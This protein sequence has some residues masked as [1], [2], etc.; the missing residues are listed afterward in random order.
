MGE[1]FDVVHA[2][3]PRNALTFTALFL[4]K[5]QAVPTVLTPHC[6]YPSHR[7]LEGAAKWL[8]DSVVMPRTFNLADRVINLTE[9]DCRDSLARGL[10]P[11]KC[12]IIPNSVRVTELAGVGPVDFRRKWALPWDFILHI[13]RFDWVKNIEFLVRAQVHLKP[14]GLV[15]IGQDD[16]RLRAV[17]HLVRR[18]RL[19]EYVRIIPRASFK[20]VC[21]AYQQAR[22]VV[23]ASRYE[24]LPTVVLEA[25]Y[26]G[27]PVVASRVGGIPYVL[28]DESIGMCYTLNDQSEYL[29]CVKRALASDRAG[30]ALRRSLVEQE[31]S[32]EVNARRVL[33][34]YR[35]LQQVMS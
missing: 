3:M 4:A 5:Q 13:G 35:E 31:Y 16:G 34:V 27:C 29:A 19:E 17:R 14:L 25:L 32:W 22:V 30:G 1:R 23:L 12:R 20:D 18:L 6:F 33:D 10:V 24:G 15:L 2:H 28:R 8:Y 21:G 7:W 11:E 9:S 26:F